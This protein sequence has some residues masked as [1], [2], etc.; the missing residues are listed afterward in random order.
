MLFRSDISI[1]FQN[2]AASLDP[3]CRIEDQLREVI[4]AHQ[5]VSRN[6]IRQQIRH[7]LHV[8]QLDTFPGIER[9]YPHELSGGMAQRVLIAMAL[10]NHPELLIADEPTSNV[11]VTTQRELLELFRRLNNEERLAV[12]FISHDLQVLSQISTRI[13]VM[14]DG[15]IVEHGPTQ[16]VLS[17]PKTAYVQG[18]IAAVPKWN[19]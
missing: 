10:A 3:L 6:E 1:I 4:Q 19:F 18:L 9:A 16:E 15:R 11:D 17:A 14:R 2:A 13:I 5:S 12:V 7:L 8:A